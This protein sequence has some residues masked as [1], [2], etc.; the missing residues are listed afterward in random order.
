[1][2][3]LTIRFVFILNKK[4]KLFRNEVRKKLDFSYLRFRTY[5]YIQFFYQ[6]TQLS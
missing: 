3:Y 6:T 2:A 1:M 4:K 5:K